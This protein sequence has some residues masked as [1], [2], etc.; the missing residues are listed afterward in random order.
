[1]SPSPTRK[2]DPERLTA[3]RVEQDLMACEVA[4]GIVSRSFYGR[5]ERGEKGASPRVARLLARRLGVELDQITTVVRTGTRTA[6]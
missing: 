2:I 1:M 5:L 4:D 3:A 6:A